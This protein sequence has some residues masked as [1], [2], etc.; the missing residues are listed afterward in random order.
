LL[1]WDHESALS[2]VDHHEASE[3]LFHTVIHLRRDAAAPR[4]RPRPR[5]RPDPEPN[6]PGGQRCPRNLQTR[7]D[8]VDESE[9]EDSIDRE[10]LEQ[11]PDAPFNKVLSDEEY[12]DKGRAALSELATANEEYRKPEN[13]DK[14]LDTPVKDWK[15]GY[16]AMPDP[17]MAQHLQQTGDYSLD[18]FTSS[19]K[20]IFKDLDLDTNTRFKGGWVKTKYE[21]DG[22]KL[23]VQDNYFSTNGRDGII[24]C[25]WNHM[26]RT[27]NEVVPANERLRWSDMLLEQFKDKRDGGAVDDLKYLIR[28]EVNNLG[29]KQKVQAAMKDLEFTRDTQTGVSRGT[30]EKTSK[31]VKVQTHFTRLTGT[32]HGT[33]PTLLLKDH[34]TTFKGKEIKKIHLY[35]WDER[36]ENYSMVLEMGPA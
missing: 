1:D 11:D 4:P 34:V 14:N 16:V 35:S 31:D 24:L 27:R 25:R 18:A 23:L 21:Q 10:S 33:A 36:G 13:I 20:G 22:A 19:S 3:N 30:L 12:D 15:E 28:D 2:R 7:A 5:P 29:S 6:H 32:V 9:D 17:M 8:C 26:D